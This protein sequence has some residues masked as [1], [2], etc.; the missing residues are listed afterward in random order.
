MFCHIVVCCALR[1]VDLFLAA[2]RN[3]SLKNACNVLL[4]SVLYCPVV[5][6]FVLYYLPIGTKKDLKCSVM[7]CTL[8]FCSVMCCFVVWCRLLS[9]F[10]LSC[11]TKDFL[12]SPHLCRLAYF[13]MVSNRKYLSILSTSCIYS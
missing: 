13:F 1:C 10:V 11:F 5:Y 12:P 9:C 2:K 7:F 4:C 3:K 6:C 8:L